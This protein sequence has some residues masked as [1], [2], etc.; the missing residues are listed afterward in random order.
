MFMLLKRYAKSATAQQTPEDNA[1]LFGAA[2]LLLFALLLVA[3]AG[4]AHMP[5]IDEGVWLYIAKA[6]TRHGLAP[7]TGALENKTPGIFF[8]FAGCD[9]FFAKPLLAARLLGALLLACSGALVWKIADTLSGKTA[10]LWSLCA[11]A[12]LLLNYPTAPKY[13]AHTEVFM[14]VFSVL[15]FYIYLRGRGRGAGTGT[16][17]CSGLAMGVAVLFKQVALPTALALA[18]WPFFCEDKPRRSKFAEAA[19]ILAGVLAVNSAALG[20][21]AFFGTKPADYFSGA[22]LSLFKLLSVPDSSTSSLSLRVDTAARTWSDLIIF[23][24]PVLLFFRQRKRWELKREYALLLV[25]WLV[26]D[27]IGVNLSGEY[28]R[29]QFKQIAPALALFTGVA[30]A[31]AEEI[32]NRFTKM[33]VVYAA[34]LFAVAGFAFAAQS[35]YVSYTTETLP[36]LSMYAG[37]LARSMTGPADYVYIC[38]HRAS[39][40]QL[41]A[42]RLSPTKYFNTIFVFG[43]KEQREI[44]AALEANPPTLIL[45]QMETPLWLEGFITTHG[46][47]FVR[48]EYN[49]TFYRRP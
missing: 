6:W 35:L 4:F 24:V 29:H 8:V 9:L 49:Y 14:V 19:L 26:A 10:A 13:M 39:Q 31:N 48:R 47:R 28:F 2:V 36:N 7:Y 11:Y 23:I 46:Y 40:A 30:A 5:L 32:K 20:V 17:F 18:A 22:W 44:L 37:S 42:D 21:L 12:A 33:Q 27:F 25:C 41:Y 3:F 1:I 34:L 43:E 45:A 16:A 38:E 15:A